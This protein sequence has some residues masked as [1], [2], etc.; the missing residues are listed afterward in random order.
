MLLNLSVP[1]HFGLESVVKYELAKIGAENISAADGKVD[2]S[3]DVSSLARANIRLACG[4]RVRI[5]LAEFYAA[6]FQDLIDEAEAIPFEDFIGKNDKFPV[7]GKAL[8]CALSSVPRIQATIK[9]AAV[10]RLSKKYGIENFSETDNLFQIEFTAIKNI[11]RIYLDSSGAGL[12]K[13]GYRPRS[14]AAPIKETLAAGMIDLA[15]I[16]GTDRL[17]DPFCGSGTILIEAIYKAYNIAPGLKRKF[18]AENWGFIPQKIWEDEREAARADIK[19]DVQFEVFGYDNDPEAIALTLENAKHA[20]VAN[21]LTAK[22]RDIK[23]F[24]QDGGIVVTNPPYGERMLEIR[25]A[26]RLYEE[27]GRHTP[28][29]AAVIS[30]SEEFEKFFGRRAFKKRKLYNGMMKC[31]LFLFK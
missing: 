9:K 23:Q 16:R 17:F 29:A 10:N 25:D 18:A 12:H 7:K 4:E 15:R 27:L 22:T 1:C 13:R 8:D 11:F 19:T 31:N 5:L 6:T 3:G 26:E 2:F 30:P 24:S 21:K 20:G 28:G 14:N